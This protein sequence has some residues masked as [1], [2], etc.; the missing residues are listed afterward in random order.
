[1]GLRRP[2][3]TGSEYRRLKLGGTDGVS[4]RIRAEKQTLHGSLE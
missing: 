1:M 2:D 4:L 3:G